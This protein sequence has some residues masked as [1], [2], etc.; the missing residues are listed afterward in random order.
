MSDDEHDDDRREL[1]NNSSPLERE[2]K[3]GRKREE[4]E[5]SVCAKKNHFL[6]GNVGNASGNVSR[7]LPPILTIARTR[8]VTRKPAVTL[9]FTRLCVQ[10]FSE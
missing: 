6:V 3:R 8:G 9:R 10:V 2:R 5:E 4:E 1:A 7:K